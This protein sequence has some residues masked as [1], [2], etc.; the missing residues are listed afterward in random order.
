MNE[1]VHRRGSGLIEAARKEMESVFNRFFGP[2][3]ETDSDSR[4]AWSPRVDVSESDK[5]VTVVADV[6]GVDPKDVEITLAEGVLTIKGEKIEEHEEKDKNFHKTERFVGSFY[7]QVVLPFG[8]DEHKVTATSSHGTI[9]ITIPKKPSA[10]P[11]KVTIK[12]GE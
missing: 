10:Q 3:T 8:T 9:T 6:P 11:K 7:R 5:A 1:I 4:Q 12:A 2:M